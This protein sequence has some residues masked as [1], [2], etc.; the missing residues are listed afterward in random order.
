MGYYTDFEVDIVGDGKE[1]AL[2]TLVNISGYSW[3]G[4]YLSD[5]KWYN[6]VEDLEKVSRM[7]PDCKFT[8]NGV[9]ED[10]PDI[11]QATAMNGVV[12]KKNATI[13]FT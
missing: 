13:S 12:I 1:D 11:W 8:L 9:G 5:A 2:A 7:H 3:Y 6:W 4:N 10:H